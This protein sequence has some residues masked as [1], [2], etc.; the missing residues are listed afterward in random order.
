MFEIFRDDKVKLPLFQT[1]H[2]YHTYNTSMQLLV[3]L[4]YRC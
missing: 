3:V 2:E 1:Y 4:N